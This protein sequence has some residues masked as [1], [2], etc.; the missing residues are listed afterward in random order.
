MVSSITSLEDSSDEFSSSHDGS[1]S[2]CGASPDE[3]VINDIV[4]TAVSSS[5]P[6]TT[7]ILE[8][9][10][11]D[12]DD[13]GHIV[14]PTSAVP[15]SKSCAEIPPDNSPRPG[16]RLLTFRPLNPDCSHYDSAPS[17]ISSTPASS[18]PNSPRP[19]PKI[20]SQEKEDLW[21][22]SNSVV[23]ARSDIPAPPT[24]SVSLSSFSS[25]ADPL[26]S[27][28]GRGASSSGSPSR[29][30]G[31]GG[32]PS[33]IPRFNANRATSASYSVSP[34]SSPI[35]CSSTGAKAESGGHPRTS[36]IPTTCQGV[37]LLS[38]RSLGET[39][40]FGSGATSKI[41]KPGGRGGKVEGSTPVR[42]GVGRGSVGRGVGGDAARR[43]GT[44]SPAGCPSSPSG[45]DVSST[46]YCYRGQEA[47][48]VYPSSA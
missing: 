31:G 24:S 11:D 33:R 14:S 45:S 26:A 39:S 18:A 29:G 12:D 22:L 34:T 36:N 21:E 5:N 32:S 48:P 44:S 4:A 38:Q 9:A 6:A 7:T 19:L 15:K 30:S 42:G 25:S 8:E 46:T 3:N 37:Q 10:E 17:S 47:N 20:P 41:P 2:P 16:V 13:Y 40:T 27:A 1:F 43:G 28:S 35:A 23:E